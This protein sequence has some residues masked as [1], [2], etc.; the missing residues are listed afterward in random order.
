MLAQVFRFRIQAPIQSLSFS[1]CGLVTSHWVAA[2]CGPG[3]LDSVV[4]NDGREFDLSDGTIVYNG[5]YRT[6]GEHCKGE[7]GGRPHSPIQAVLNNKAQAVWEVTRRL[8]MTSN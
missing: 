1:A 4:M 5:R 7:V 6:T 8:V 3:G 2:S